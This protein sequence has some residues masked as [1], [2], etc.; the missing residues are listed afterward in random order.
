VTPA[1]TN[2]EITRTMTEL[3][4]WATSTTKQNRI[5]HFSDKKSTTTLVSLL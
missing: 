1:L 4:S 2:A 5:Y 3:S